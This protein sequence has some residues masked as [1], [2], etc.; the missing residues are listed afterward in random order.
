MKPIVSLLVSILPSLLRIPVSDKKGGSSLKPSLYYASASDSD[1]FATETD[2]PDSQAKIPVKDEHS[3]QKAITVAASAES[4]DYIQSNFANNYFRHLTNNIPQN[5]DGIC[6]FTSR[7]R[8]LSYYDI[9]WNDDIIDNK[10]QTGTNANLNLANDDISSSYSSPGVFDKY[11]SMGTYLEDDEKYQATLPSYDY[12]VWKETQ[13]LRYIKD[14]IDS[15]SFLGKLYQTTQEC[16]HLTQHSP[17]SNAFVTSAGVSYDLMKDTLSQYISDNP[18]RRSSVTLKS[19]HIDKDKGPKN[20]IRNKII[21]E[22][23]TGN[24]VIV[25]GFVRNDK[26][27]ETNSG[28]DCIA[29]YYDSASDKIYGNLGWGKGYT[30]SDLDSYFYAFTD[31]YHLQINSL[32]HIHGSHYTNKTTGTTICS[33]KLYTH[34]HY[35][36]F[37]YYND[38]Y[39]GD[40]C[41]CRAG[42]NLQK[43]NFV[44]TTYYG[45]VPWKECKTCGY[46]G[47]NY[48]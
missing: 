36:H 15:G 38:D 33:C 22:L 1:S 5:Y 8:L 11:I 23:N 12:N 30:Y 35:F 47:V 27:E 7:S 4:K 40:V 28:H 25:G 37:G 20:Y 46:Q 10:Y 3:G 48:H 13:V 6:G 16:G 45:G 17:G 24:P 41:F 42:N 31:Y 32:S 9:L 29:Y 44:Y 26:G 18:T 19:E 2:N 43:H 34:K 39:H 14:N 21:S